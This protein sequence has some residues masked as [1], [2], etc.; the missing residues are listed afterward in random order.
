MR[1]LER[2]PH[3]LM[4]EAIAQ[5]QDATFRTV[6]EL[7]LAIP[8]TLDATLLALSLEEG[9]AK[10]LA[11]TNQG[12]FPRGGGEALDP[13]DPWC[14][15]ILQEKLPVL[16]NDEDGLKHYL[17]EVEDIIKAGYG[18]SGSFPIIIAG[19]VAG[20]LNLLGPDGF[21]TAETVA[22]VNTLIP[23]AAIALMLPE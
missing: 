9:R 13:S 12:L 10:R 1:K 7:A 6:L 23:Y 18:A 22:S 14:Q 2:S 11:S 21:F 4:S 3:I 19:R 5:G 16:A 20:T 15:R 17:T 8:G